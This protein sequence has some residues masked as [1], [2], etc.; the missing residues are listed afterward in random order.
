M[1]DERLSVVCRI[2]GEDWDDAIAWFTEGLA[3]EGTHDVE[4]AGKV[5]KNEKRIL[6]LKRGILH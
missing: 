3:V 6:N 5:S 4:L 1:L 2:A